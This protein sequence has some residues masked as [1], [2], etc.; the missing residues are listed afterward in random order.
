MIKI[1]YDI[2]VMV[3]YIIYIMCAQVQY[4]NLLEFLFDDL[5]DINKLVLLVVNS[6]RGKV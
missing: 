6:E 5:H 4:F 3:Q 2:S 1:E